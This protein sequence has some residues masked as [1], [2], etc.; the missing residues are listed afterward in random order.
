MMLKKLF[1]KILFKKLDSGNCDKK[2]KINKYFIEYIY[3]R[4][5]DIFIDIKNNN[6]KLIFKLIWSLEIRLEKYMKIM[7]KP[8]IIIKNIKIEYI[9]FIFHIDIKRHLLKLK[10]IINIIKKIGWICFIKIKNIM[11]NNKKIK[12][13]EINW[14]KFI[15]I[16]KVV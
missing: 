14:I 1:I 16:Q 6:F 2:F 11:K 9:K 10:I 15:I 4:G 7:S 5:N 13:K 8:L 3:I 12:V